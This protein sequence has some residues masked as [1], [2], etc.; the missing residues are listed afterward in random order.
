[1]GITKDD[2]E[3]ASVEH[4]DTPTRRYADTFPSRLL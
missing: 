4:A 1:M 3:Y 2:E